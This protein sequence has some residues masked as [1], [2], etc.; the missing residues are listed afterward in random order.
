M[1]QLPQLSAKDELDLVGWAG[2]N[3]IMRIITDF[4]TIPD[5][6]AK[7]APQSL[8]RKGRPVVSFPFRLEDVP[9]EARYLHWM[10]VDPDSVPVCGFPWIHWSLA[11]LPIE[12]L[13]ALQPEGTGSSVL[14]I[15]EDFSRN[16]SNLIPGVPQGRT[17][18]ASPLVMEEEIADDP[19]V[20]MRYNGPT[21]PDRAHDYVLS[22]WATQE[23]LPGLEEG[24]WLNALAHAIH[25]AQPVAAAARAWLPADA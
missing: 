2:E 10:L 20:L 19:A 1:T 15:P 18:A 11:N 4:G 7:R 13:L 6:Y 5:R 8:T 23:A 17:S 24:F 21:P 9:R 3:R 14:A 16:L 12:A 25:S 22:V